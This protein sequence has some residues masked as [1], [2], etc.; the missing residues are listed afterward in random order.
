MNITI[1]PERPGDYAA[2]LRLTYEAF[3]TLDFPGRRRVDEHYLIHL[4]QNCE[5]VISELSLVAEADGEIVGHILYTKSQVVCEGKEDI[6]TITFGPLS[7]SP[8]YH[9]KGIGRLLVEQS[10]N[11]ARELGAV[12]VIITG[13]PAYYPK[14]GF[15]RAGEFGLSLPDG[16]ADDAFMA[17]ELTPGILS[18]GAAEAGTVHFLAEAVFEQTENDDEGFTAFH[19]AFI[20]EHFPDTLLVRRLFDDDIAVMERWLKKPHV[21]QWYRYPGHFL[22]EMQER[23]GEFAFITPFI[24][25]YNGEPVG[26]CQ[27]YDCH[28]AQK[29]EIW[30]EYPYISEQKGE[31]FGMDILIGSTEYQGKG[32]GKTMVE[33]MLE[34]LREIGAKKVIVQPEK[35]NAPSCRLLES[36]GFVYNGKN[37]VKEWR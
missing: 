18:G 32:F 29:H 26:F 36:C 35:E 13:V 10:M 3:T 4:L 1:C 12:A 28:Y 16:S 27:Y 24:A 19:N 34:K 2:I 7:I 31:V 17:Y 20:A 8:K 33:H 23:H 9:R 22:Q 21:A 15:I 6:P 30:N 11:K 25:E 5:H 14:L 37:Y